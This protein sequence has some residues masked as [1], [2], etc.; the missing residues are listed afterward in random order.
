M[1]IPQPQSE[2]GRDREE[3]YRLLRVRAVQIWGEARTA[4]IE[5]ALRRISDALWKLGSLE[6]ASDDRPGFFLADLQQVA[7]LDLSP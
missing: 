7:R 6:F 5:P 4:A 1:T 3:A 2:S